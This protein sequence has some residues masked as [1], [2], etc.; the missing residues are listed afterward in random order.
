MLPSC[1]FLSEKK[2]DMQ[3]TRSPCNKIEYSC[4]LVYLFLDIITKPGILVRLSGNTSYGP[5]L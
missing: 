5:A 1:E 2:K 4:D 3:A